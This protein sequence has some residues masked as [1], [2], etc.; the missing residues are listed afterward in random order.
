ML[1]E[2]LNEVVDRGFTILRL[3]QLYRYLERG[4]RAA[5]TWRSL[6]DAWEGLGQNRREL[7]I[8]E[9]PY[10]TLLLTRYG[11]ERVTLWAAE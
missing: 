1:N 5:G 6:L 2:Y 7:Q 11:V 4:N 8:V 9:L 10:E 3:S